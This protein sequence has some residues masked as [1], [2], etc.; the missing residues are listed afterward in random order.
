[1]VRFH[2][3]LIEL[4][5]RI[6]RI[7]LSEKTHAIAV[8]IACSSFVASAAASIAVGWREPVPGRDFSPAEDQRLSTAHLRAASIRHLTGLD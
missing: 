5:V 8:A 3:P 6:C 2:I 1:M 7:R 4:G